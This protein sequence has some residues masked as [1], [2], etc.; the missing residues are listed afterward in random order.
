M[1]TLHFLLLSILVAACRQN[2][3]PRAIFEENKSMLSP[4]ERYGQLFIDAQMAS[5]FPD[6]KT[7]VDCRPKYPTDQILNAYSIA[8]EQPD[9]D[10]ATFVSEYFELPI[11]YATDFT[12]DPDRP[13][14]AHIELLWDI[15]T[16]QPDEADNSTLIPMPEAYVVPGGR[17][18][19]IYYWD[20]Y[21]TMQ[22]LVVSGRTDLIESMVN[23]FS[24]LIDTLGFIPNG[25]RT[26]FTTRS[27]PPFFAP[28]VQLLG[29]ARGNTTETLVQY[30]PQMEKEYAFWM[31]GQD[32]LGPNRTA[33]EHVVQLA[34]N[35]ILNRYW[36]R[37]D[38]P[39]D[40]MYRA[41]VESWE[42]SNREPEE[43][44][45]DI[46]SA[47]E[48]GW[49]FSS[50]WLEDGQNLAEIIT[51]DII[52]VDLNALLYGM[53]LILAAANEAS[54]QVEKAALFRQKAEQ[55]K[56]LVNHYC[57]DEALGFYRDYN[58]RKAEF[59]PVISLAGVFPLYFNMA[60]EAQAR[61]TASVLQK[62]FLR[63]GGLVSTLNRTGQQWDAPNGW[64][65]LQLI[66]I[67]GLRHYGHEQLAREI[68]Q[69][70][71]DLN[72]KV[73]QNTGKLV[74]KYNVEDISLK[75]GGGEYPVQDGFGWTNGTLLYL[76]NQP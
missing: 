70:W 69:R 5:V 68:S 22:G 64:A 50:R 26:Y 63:P 11:A 72:V 29:E 21:F 2:G 52:P 16:R 9:F 65:P 24:H 32:K 12:S 40:E 67:D 47:C 44:Y 34:A 61:A 31:N 18:G 6:G 27:Q 62:E 13:V 43:F 73:Y 14:E 39:R 48:S 58:F 75:S 36:D 37:G 55:R 1:R 38:Y 4:H 56:A 28:M 66:A 76:M 7:F 33:V 71:I 45:R 25:N 57:W 3:G 41:D 35:S 42:A 19:E 60:D 74:E 51:T 53:E 59:T 46:R 15:L 23:N 30:L 54:A 8:K 17:F 49:D 10:I 20:S